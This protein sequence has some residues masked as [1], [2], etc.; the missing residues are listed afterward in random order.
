[1]LTSTCFHVMNSVI[2]LANCQD[3]WRNKYKHTII[4]SESTKWPDNW[5][6]TSKL[7]CPS[8]SRLAQPSFKKY[9]S[10]TSKLKNG[11]TICREERRQWVNS[12]A[13]GAVFHDFEFSKQLAITHPFSVFHG[14]FW[15][16]QG[17]LER[18]PIAPKIAGRIHL[19]LETWIKTTLSA[20]AWI[21][22]ISGKEQGQ[23][24]TNRNVSSMRY[25]I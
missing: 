5:Q 1:M 25:V 4:L 24:R 10:L 3:F 15:P 14:A 11:M 2:C 23:E 8:L 18:R 21:T 13:S 16:P 19:M 22:L 6:L 12:S 20:T 7:M 9:M 17:S